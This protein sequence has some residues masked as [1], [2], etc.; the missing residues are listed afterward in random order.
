MLHASDLVPFPI[1]MIKYTLSKA[2]C[3]GKITYL[4]VQGY[5]LVMIE[6]SLRQELE[7]AGHPESAVKNVGL[8]HT[9]TQPTSTFVQCRAPARSSATHGRLIFRY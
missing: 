1:A 4:K 7:A 6:K 5:N 8:M 2:T 9:A 3:G